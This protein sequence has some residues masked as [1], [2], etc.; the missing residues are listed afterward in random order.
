MESTKKVLLY[1]SLEALC[2]AVIDELRKYKAE[3][4]FKV[5]PYQQLPVSKIDYD[6]GVFYYDWENIRYFDYFDWDM[7]DY[8]A[9]AENVVKLL[10][11]Y[12]Q[13]TL[14]SIDFFGE[15]ID[16]DILL[17]PLIGKLMKILPNTDMTPDALKKM[18]LFFIDDCVSQMREDKVWWRVDVWLQ[19]IHLGC[20][21][22][23]LAEG[24]V[25][26]R[27]NEN[28]LTVTCPSEYHDELARITGRSLGASA[29]L[30]FTFAGKRRPSFGAYPSELL[31]E[32]EDW[33][34]IFR[35]Y[36]VA[37]VVLVYR[38]ITAKTF[39]FV[40][41]EANPDLPYEKSWE[42]KVE[43]QHT[44][45]F[46]LFINKEDET[47]LSVFAARV[48]V[49]F[50]KIKSSA[51]LSGDY[52]DIAVHRYTDALI[53]SEVNVYRILSAITALEAVLS[54][55]GTEITF[56]IR[57]RTAKLLSF[58]LF[59]SVV[60]TDHIK[61]AYDIRSKL[62]HGGKLAGVGKKDSLNW[63]KEHTHTILNYTRICILIVLQLKQKWGKDKLL[64]ILDN[65]FVDTNA[66]ETLA[67][68][69][70]KEVYVSQI[71]EKSA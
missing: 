30:T 21:K 26:R 31:E 52:C 27:L 49:L 67:A 16:C 47:Q 12:K 65:S 43:H 50:S 39:Y 22:V 23:E 70:Q 2:N 64:E 51:Y 25:L 68:Y 29:I 11:A 69:I 56:K 28:D 44:S 33:L 13:A 35:F 53:K 38:K 36:K 4:R 24:I 15:P 60:V 58:F 42:G 59:N 20:D 63:A 6:S 46:K 66:N 41:Y 62:V 5:I 18:L 19:N 54:D 32:I 34:N 37:D 57:L 71:G 8:S 61:T 14:K 7:N 10:P 9:F 48:K 17:H 1:Q 40:P 55:S 3:K 45:T